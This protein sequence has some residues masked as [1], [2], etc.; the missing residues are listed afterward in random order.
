MSPFLQQTKMLVFYFYLGSYVVMGKTK[1][2]S[3]D[4]LLPALPTA[5]HTRAAVSKELFESLGAKPDSIP[6]ALQTAGLKLFSGLS[7]YD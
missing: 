4:C 2:K 6:H 5:Q 1:P 3:K 7:L